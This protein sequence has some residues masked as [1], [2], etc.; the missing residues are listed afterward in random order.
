[1]DLRRK[2]AA[3][4]SLDTG[5]KIVSQEKEEADVKRVEKA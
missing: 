4:L 3:G 1:M 2:K 5:V